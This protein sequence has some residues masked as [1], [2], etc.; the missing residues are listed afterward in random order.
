MISLGL[1]PSLTGFGWC[2]HNSRVV[3]PGR[4]L[5]KGRLSTNTK[6]VFV[7][8]YMFMRQS[9]I[10]L[11]VAFP[12]VKAVGV[13][14][15][16]LGDGWSMELIM[17]FLY[18]N[19][20][21]FLQRR[22]VIYFDPA[23]V[24]LLAKGDPKIRRGRMDKPDMI[25]AAKADTTIKQWNHDEADAYILARSAARF[26]DLFEGHITEDTLTPAEQQVFTHTRT[27]TKGHRKG[28][29]IKKGLLFKEGDRFFQFGLLGPKDTTVAAAEF[30]RQESP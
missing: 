2:V 17:L 4:V 25:E 30:T 15:P 16:P 19:E 28:R 23:R 12:E 5:A 24:K 13:E 27:I 6:Q 20:A 3:G 7:C 26:W 14:S 11:L 21:V 18:V 10:N 1:D 22:N 8:R 9:I 29:T